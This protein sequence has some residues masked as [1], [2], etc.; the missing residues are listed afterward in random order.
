MHTKSYTFIF[1]LSVLLLLAFTA[2]KKEMPPQFSGENFLYFRNKVTFPNPDGTTINT[3]YLPE[4]P[5]SFLVS[6][7]N[8]DTVK[9]NEWPEFPLFI[10]T[11]GK[12][13][14]NDRPV[15]LEVKGTG[16]EYVIFPHP[17][18]IF[19]KANEIQYKL[20]IKFIKPPASDT[21]MKTLTLVLK[22][23]EPFKPENHIWSSI[24]YKFGNW[25]NK[26]LFYYLSETYFGDFSAAKMV[27]M[28]EA[29]NSEAPDYWEND[30]D[31]IMIN[32]FLQ[33]RNQKILKFD[34]FT[35]YDIYQFNDMLNLVS[36]QPADPVRMAYDAVAKKIISLTKVLLVERK[37]AGHPV[38]DDSG[39]EISFP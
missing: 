23:N 27:A 7:Y 4:Q 11:D 19:I 3:A 39:R 17:D 21:S 13:F 36:E 8:L 15:L 25:F 32:N 24:T 12:I 22:N 38:L 31:V 26:P 33:L 18:S 16:K 14:A 34:P 35:Y 30:P 37:N 5:F 28:T 2:C 6:R 29:V 9:T 1:H 10:Q 20:N